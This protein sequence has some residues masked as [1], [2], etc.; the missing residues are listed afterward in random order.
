MNYQFCIRF[1]NIDVNSAASKAVLDCNRIFSDHGY[2][3]YT[4]TVQDNLN[5]LPYYYSLV[6]GLITFFFSV[7]RGS[8]VG[9]QYPLLSINNVF[10]YFIKVARVKKVKFFCVV[11]D[12]E[13][14]RSGAKDI[15]LIKREVNNLNYYTTLIVHNPLM[16]AWLKEQG[17]TSKMISL[18]L[19]DYLV[20]YSDVKKPGMD[21]S[22]V[23]A[24]NLS[25]STFIYSLSMISQI[26]FNL[27]G[28][29]FNAERSNTQINTVW[30]GQYSPDEIPNKLNGKFG[31]IWDGNQIDACDEKLGNYLKYNNPH[32]CS[33]YVAAGLPVIA[34]RDSA[35]GAFII[36]HNIGVVIDN[37]Y[38]LNT[39]KIDDEL[40]G[41]LKTNVITIKNKVI[42]GGYF[43]D[44]LNLINNEYGN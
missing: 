9:I 23:Y 10:K 36:Q 14:L 18:E 40:Y 25:K 20:S 19:F 38:D 17:V 11:H 43:S 2:K 5:K 24:G 42:K 12:L 21:N 1:N 22:I 39:F 44:A 30:K 33:L 37:L 32:K 35:I 31:L 15:G 7:K 13:S 16:I 6:K 4:F 8:V 34:P 26:N 29:G 28:P 3:D 41:V 27:Y